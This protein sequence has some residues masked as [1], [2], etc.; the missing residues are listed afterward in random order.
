MRRLMIIE[1]LSNDK[2][3]KTLYKDTKKF[4]KKNDP[5]MVYIY[6]EYDPWSASGVLELKNKDNIKIYVN[7]KGSHSTRINSFPEPT[8]SEIINVIKGWLEE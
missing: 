7:P 5:K 2:F 6:G 4:L 3:D 8:K 1:E